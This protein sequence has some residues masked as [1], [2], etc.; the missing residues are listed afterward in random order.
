M[1]ELIFSLF[2]IESGNDSAC[3]LWKQVTLPTDQSQCPTLVWFSFGDSPSHSWEHYSSDHKCQRWSSFR[4]ETLCSS[5][6]FHDLFTQRFRLLNYFPH[7]S[8]T[9]AL[10]EQI[11]SPYLSSYLRTLQLFSESP[12]FYAL[13]SH[14]ILNFVSGHRSTTLGLILTAF[15]KSLLPKL[16]LAQSVRAVFLKPEHSQFTCSMLLVTLSFKLY[17]TKSHGVKISPTPMRL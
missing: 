3:Q 5:T 11:P 16:T 15:L 7:L 14:G 17:W 12:S 6:H 13:S 4:R 1:R 10:Q 2:Q 9:C 8:S